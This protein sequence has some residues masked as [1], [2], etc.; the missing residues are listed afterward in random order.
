[1][2]TSKNR[3]S[4]LRG[5]LQH[6]VSHH[7]EPGDSATITQSR[8]VALATAIASL[9]FAW[10]APAF[11]V[12]R[13]V[14]TNWSYWN[15]SS[16]WL[17]NA[18]PNSNDNAFVIGNRGVY[19][20][21]AEPNVNAIYVGQGLT[22]GQNTGV[23]E[24]D[25]G[26]SINTNYIF[27][28]RDSSNDGT[29]NNNGGTVTVNSLLEI[30]NPNNGGG[31]GIFNM[32][33]GTV[34]VVGDTT[35]GN[36]S[37]NCQLI[38][39]GGTFHTGTLKVGVGSLS[40]GVVQSSSLL[41]SNNLSGAPFGANSFS[42]G[43]GITTI[44]GTTTVV[45]GSTLSLAGGI[46]NTGSLDMSG[47]TEN[48]H[49]TGGALNLTNSN[50]TIGTGGAIGTSIHG[51][52]A[53]SGQGKTLTVDTGGSLSGGALILNTFTGNVSDYAHNSIVARSFVQ[54]AGL[55]FASYTN[56]SAAATL[57]LNGG[58]FR[59]GLLSGTLANFHWNG[60]TL[61]LLDAGLVNYTGASIGTGGDLG[62]SLA[63]SATKKLRVTGTGK[64]LK[65]LSGGTLSAG[66][67][68]VGDP[69]PYGST[70]AEVFA[71]GFTQ[72]GGTTT[73]NGATTINTGATLSLSGGRIKTNSLSEAGNFNWTGGTLEL[74]GGVLSTQYSSFSVDAN[75]I[76]AGYGTIMNDTVVHGTLQLTPHHL[77]SISIDPYTFTALTLSGATLQLAPALTATDFAQ[78]GN[79]HILKASHIY[80]T[81]A[82][83]RV[84]SADG[85][86][87][88]GIQY[89]ATDVWL[90]GYMID[91]APITVATSNV[92][93][94]TDLLGGSTSVG[95]V[96]TSF[97]QVATSGA[98]TASYQTLSASE[99]AAQT[100]TANFSLPGGTA[101]LWDLHFNGSF[102]GTTRVTFHYDPSLLGGLA[103]TSLQ[104]YH[105][106]GGQWVLLDN[107][108]VDTVN[109][110]I[111]ADTPSFSPFELGG[112]LSS[113]PE[114][115][116]L[117][118]L[119]VGAVGLTMRQ[120]RRNAE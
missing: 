75:C 22:A 90:S 48:F 50:L 92:P 30:G 53:V 103:E 2:N 17:L 102:T 38:Y 78:A 106:T 20:N 119:G 33:S 120:R 6:P 47:H 109:D 58:T 74:N 7:S 87:S 64:T 15:T 51:F 108:V 67:L 118:L 110:L 35:V 49:W 34:N 12:D 69:G 86:Q 23:V 84:V 26:G 13:I 25:V 21:Q 56:I 104:L 98:M 55:T 94:A 80:G 60:G 1:M 85:H 112:P 54:N 46:F 68:I 61:E 39:S 42:Q 72:N 99:L 63:T 57:T 100:G 8:R 71:Q 40:S 37:T 93:Q 66:S 5:K 105:F 95:G 70:N 18:V 41:V 79:T 4:S 29:W 91:S 10:A 19:I 114:P 36:E 76:L 59:T 116:S 88:W 28:S 96:T 83:Q 27:L 111:S 62:P 45:N 115:T 65:I 89:S 16:N 77:L 31:A 43:N 52:L 117:T 3:T 101:Q 113:V 73:I 82:N 11:A 44:S 107:Q 14:Q 32:N 97:N 24:S 81:F 9:S